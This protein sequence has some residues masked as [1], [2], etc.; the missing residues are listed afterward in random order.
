LREWEISRVANTTGDWQVEESAAPQALP[1]ERM[2]YMKRPLAFYGL[3]TRF[4]APLDPAGRTLVV[5]YELRYQGAVECGGSYIKLFGAGNFAPAALCNETRYVVMF[6]PDRCGAV[7]RVHFV[8]RHRDARTGRYAERHL[9]DPPPPR[10]DALTHLYTLIVRADNSVEILIDGESVRQ[11]SLLAD[12]E[13]PV[14]P[15][16]FVDDP[17]DAKP[18]GWVDAEQIDD[19]DAR[20]PPDWDDGEP[21]F[22]VDPARRNPPEGWLPDEPRFV[23]DPDARRPDEWEDDV[24]GDWEPPIIANPKCASAPGCGPFDPP[25]V[26]NPKYRGKW[27]PPRIPNP[28]YKGP[29]RPRQIPNPAFHEDLHPH[30]FEPIIGAGFELWMIGRDVGYANVFIGTDEAAVHRWNKAHFIPKFKRQEEERRRLMPDDDARDVRRRDPVDFATGLREFAT[31][32]RNAWVNLYNDRPGVT[33][34]VAA[35]LFFVP[36]GICCLL[37]G[38]KPKKAKP[39]KR[40][41]TEIKQNE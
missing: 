1:H 6:G 40:K 20:R 30:N 9:R 17:G 8:F 2:V 7:D 26:K 36:L 4:A 32:L 13:P 34:A 41:A 22:V 18:A 5:Q 21:E 10:A 38:R 15:P 33:L 39:A 16:R 3:S 31:T 25:L 27:R 11:A 24:L 12:F 35:G 28:A 23:T 19:P 37:G 14:N 29:W